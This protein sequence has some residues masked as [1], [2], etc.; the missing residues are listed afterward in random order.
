MQIIHS[1]D[2]PA[3]IGPYSQAVKVGK[4][5]Y[6]SGQIAL[7]PKTGELVEGGV[8]AQ[9]HQVFQNLDAIARAGGGQLKQIVKLNIY[10]TNL[11]EFNLINE[12][13]KEF[14]T[15]P[16][17]ARATIGVNA[18]PRQAEVEVDAILQLD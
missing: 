13:M 9:A 1:K 8:Q 5:I 11:G 6:I 17:P 7:I 14:F 3:A 10:M 4:T 2:A 12:I 18:L 15:E 16:Y